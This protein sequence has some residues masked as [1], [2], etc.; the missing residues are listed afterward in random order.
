MTTNRPQGEGRQVVGLFGCVKS[1]RAS[2]TRAADLYTSAQFR[3][4]CRWV[5]RGEPA[6]SSCPPSTAWL[7]RPQCF[8][9]TTKR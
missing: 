6:G 8:S 7:I 1:K 2:T 4:R 5:K 9:L 3:G